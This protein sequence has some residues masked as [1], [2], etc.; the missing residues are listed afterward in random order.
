MDDTEV[1][2]V[3]GRLT[4]R[5]VACLWCASGAAL[6]GAPTGS[7]TIAVPVAGVRSAVIPSQWLAA[8]RFA[9]VLG[10][11]MPYVGPAD[12]APARQPHLVVPVALGAACPAGPGAV[13]R[14]GF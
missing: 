13:R 14:P 4:H 3:A 12:R 5:A 6:E 1:P 9:Q 7:V 2:A 11:Q 8:K 10:R